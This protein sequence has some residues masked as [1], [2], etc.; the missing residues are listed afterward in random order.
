[1]AHHG[2][3]RLAEDVHDYV[4]KAVALATDVPRLTDLRG[5]LRERLASCP[6]SDGAKFATD[7]TAAMRRIWQDWCSKI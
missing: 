3:G 4:V 5:S 2:A 6:L 1:M 7:F